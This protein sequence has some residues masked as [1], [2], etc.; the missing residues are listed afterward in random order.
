MLPTR[1]TKAGVKPGMKSKW[2][3][4]KDIL[5]EEDWIYPPMQPT[6]LQR[7]QIIGRVAEIGTRVVF[8]NLCYKFGGRHKNNRE[9]DPLVHALS[10]VRPRW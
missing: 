7:R 2:V 1:V 9:R 6:E 10:C 3:N 8:E 4:S 5:S